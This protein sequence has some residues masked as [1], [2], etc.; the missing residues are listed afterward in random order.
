MVQLDWPLLAPQPA[1]PFWG[2]TVYLYVLHL[3]LEEPDLWH[4]PYPVQYPWQATALGQP[5][6]VQSP[7]QLLYGQGVPPFVADT[8]CL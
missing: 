3:W 4:P 8:E 2:W 6:V 1:P 7:C 5:E